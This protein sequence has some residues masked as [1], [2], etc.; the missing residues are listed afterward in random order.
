MTEQ[1]DNTI[2]H[3]VYEPNHLKWKSEPPPIII[4]NHIRDKIF[5]YEQ[6]RSKAHQRMLKAQYTHIQALRQK[7][8]ED[9]EYRQRL[10]QLQRLQIEQER[11]QTEILFQLMKQAN[12][13]VYRD[14]EAKRIRR[15]IEDS[16]LIERIDLYI[17]FINDSKRELDKIIEND[18][19]SGKIVKSAY[20]NDDERKEETNSIIDALIEDVYFL[21]SKIGNSSKPSIRKLINDCYSYVLPEASSFSINSDLRPGQALQEYL[22]IRLKKEQ[23]T[24]VC[25]ECNHPYLR[26]ATHCFNCYEGRVN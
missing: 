1:D 18:P 2:F 23:D 7:Q 14:N 6:L 4:P 17:E 10:V 16:M 24:E 11:R 22:V 12:K 3:E 26:H 19:L 9:D 13:L 20:L 5:E 25:P 8:Q 21:I 15:K